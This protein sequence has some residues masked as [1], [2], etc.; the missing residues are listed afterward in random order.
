MVY[1]GEYKPNE[2]DPLKIVTGLFRGDHFGESALRS[3]KD[4]AKR[5]ASVVAV[6]DCDVLKIT[7]TDFN[8]IC[9][10]GHRVER[11]F[12]VQDIEKMQRNRQFV[13][14]VLSTSFLFKDLDV[15]QV[16][17]QKFDSLFWTKMKNKKKQQFNRSMR[18]RPSW[19]LTSTS[20]RMK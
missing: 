9:A 13:S 2:V 7:S 8:E 20:K 18:L 3:T 10:K 17:D 1:S 6:T 5:T 12:V 11:L 16:M 15:D 4:T 19:R 14:K